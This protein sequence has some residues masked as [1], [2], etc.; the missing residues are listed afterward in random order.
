V[1]DEEVR[2]FFEGSVQR[3]F[4]RGGIVRTVAE[5]GWRDAEGTAQASDVGRLRA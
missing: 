3:W 4:G 2:R 1:K 5:L